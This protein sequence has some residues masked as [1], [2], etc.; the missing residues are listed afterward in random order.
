MNLIEDNLNKIRELQKFCHPPVHNWMKVCF[1]HGLEFTI[2]EA[3]RTQQKQNKLYAQGRTAP[4]RIV[5]WTKN[6]MHT[7]R[8]AL[9]IDPVPKLFGSNLLQW[10]VQLDALAEPFGIVRSLPLI[11]LGDFRHYETGGAKM[12]EPPPSLD[13]QKKIASDR[14][15]FLKG[16]VQKRAIE[17]YL[18]LF[19]ENPH[20]E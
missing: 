3:W 13:T 19:G 5:T 10:Y 9:D 20:L 15:K 8:L 18:L 11:K 14:I 16:N 6:S 7:Q 4:G 2:A 1:A 17:R 12:P